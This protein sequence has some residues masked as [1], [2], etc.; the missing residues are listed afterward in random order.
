MR[1][2]DP[3]DFNTESPALSDLRVAK[4]IAPG[5]DGSKRFSL[6]YGE[7]LVC[8]W[9]RVYPSGILR[10]TTVELIIEVTPVVRAGDRLVA[11]RLGPKDK[12]T[13]SF[14]LACGGTLDATRRHWTVARKVAANLGLIDQ[15]V[16]TPG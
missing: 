9:H 11:L 13:R 8:V 10:Y 4:R 12:S 2:R 6:R 14:L 15:V 5:K 1:Q 3:R 7:Q 16:K